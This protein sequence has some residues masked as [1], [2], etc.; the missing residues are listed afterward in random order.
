MKKIILITGLVVAA[1]VVLGVGIASAQGLYPVRRQWSHV[2]ERR[3][4]DA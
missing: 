4:V 2:A 1:L 3:R